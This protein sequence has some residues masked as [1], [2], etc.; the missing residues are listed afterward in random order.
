[1]LG[2]FIYIKPFHY[3]VEWFIDSDK[4]MLA[5]SITGGKIVDIS[6]IICIMVQCKGVNKGG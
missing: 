3:L 5:S 6:A 1:M 2:F 4:I